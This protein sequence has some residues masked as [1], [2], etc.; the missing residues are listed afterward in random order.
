M[1]CLALKS[2]LR[3]EFFSQLSTSDEG[4]CAAAVVV[5]AEEYF[6]VDDLLDLS[7]EGVNVEEEEEEDDGEAEKRSP[8]SDVSSFDDTN[9]ES[10]TTDGG[11]STDS[12]S[13]PDDLGSVPVS[14]K[15]FSP[16]ESS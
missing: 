13:F 11:K 16:K 6:A 3:E 12:V 8:A 2:S 4:C 5:A 9:L 10:S 7:N 14:M 15:L 1:E